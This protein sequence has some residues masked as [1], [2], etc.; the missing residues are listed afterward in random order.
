MEKFYTKVTEGYDRGM[1]MGRVAR[2]KARMDM[3]L[4]R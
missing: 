1:S 2:F 4:G 3:L